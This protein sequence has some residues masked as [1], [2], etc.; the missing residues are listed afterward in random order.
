[1][2]QPQVNIKDNTLTN[3][4]HSI[5]LEGNVVNPTLRII[6]KSDSKLLGGPRVTRA[7][8]PVRFQSRLQPLGFADRG[9]DMLDAQYVSGYAVALSY[10]KDA[11]YIGTGEWEQEPYKFNLPY[12]IQVMNVVIGIEKPDQIA[13]FMLEPEENYSTRLSLLKCDYLF[14]A[15]RNSYNCQFAKY[16]ATLDLCE[17]VN[18]GSIADWKFEILNYK[19]DAYSFDVI[20]QRDVHAIVLRRFRRWGLTKKTVIKDDDVSEISNFQINTYDVKIDKN[21]NYIIVLSNQTKIYYLLINQDFVW[22]STKTTDFHKA[23]A[24]IQLIKCYNEL[25]PEGQLT[26]LIISNG[27]HFYQ[28]TFR[29]PNTHDGDNDNK[30]DWFINET[31]ENSATMHNPLKAA[32]SRDYFAI[33]FTGPQDPKTPPS[34]TPTIAVW[35]IGTKYVYEAKSLPTAMTVNSLFLISDY[36]YNL[37]ILGNSP[38][39]GSS[40]TIYNIQQMHLDV[41]EAGDVESLELIFNGDLDSVVRIG[42]KDESVN[43]GS[44]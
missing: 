21:G 35:K 3:L 17:L 10:N 28:I 19:F 44:V 23:K 8:P 13:I 24:A 42:V 18:N 9:I 30:L 34:H 40:F 1:M 15:D 26:C 39:V 31:Y 22:V 14:G 25:D 4:E 33:L 2:F 6:R 43:F 37:C 36:H 11:I 38:L 12:E 7:P 16:Y 32:L 27:A 29:D 20:L 5:L 41:L